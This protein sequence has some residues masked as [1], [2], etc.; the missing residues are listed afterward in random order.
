MQLFLFVR[1]E[2]MTLE[3]WDYIFFKEAP[4]PKTRLSADILKRLKAEF[5]HWY[6]VDLRSSGKDLIPNHLSY[7]LYIHSAIW[8]HDR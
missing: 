4:L 6:P 5:E 2:D 8:P 3:V 1:P 7:Y